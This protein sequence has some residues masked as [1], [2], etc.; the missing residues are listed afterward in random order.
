MMLLP[1]ICG[2]EVF[3]TLLAVAG[4]E[5]DVFTVWDVCI[6]MFTLIFTTGEVDVFANVLATA[7]EVFM[8]PEDGSTGVPA[9][10][11]TPVSPAGSVLL[12]AGLLGDVLG[13]FE[14]LGG[15]M[16]WQ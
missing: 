9:D 2:V 12:V 8:V 15:M 16:I 14:L 11:I 3:T 5:L 4:W 1:L 6:A 13:L 7:P 10:V